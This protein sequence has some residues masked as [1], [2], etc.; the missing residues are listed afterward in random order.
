MSN[1]FDDIIQKRFA[2]TN[3]SSF[4][5]FGA[6]IAM[7]VLCVVTDLPNYEG[8]PEIKLAV[9]LAVIIITISGICLSYFH[10]VK[11]IKNIL[12]GLDPTAIDDKRIKR[13]SGFYFFFTLGSFAAWFNL[14]AWGIVGSVFLGGKIWLAILGLPAIVMMIITWPKKDDLIRFVKVN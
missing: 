5:L 2:Q 8:P 11:W 10:K 1:E 6:L 9:T 14:G 4:L 3:R 7:L 13:A 12:A